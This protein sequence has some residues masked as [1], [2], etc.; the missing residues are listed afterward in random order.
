M[1]SRRSKWFIG[2]FAVGLVAF[3]ILQALS[4]RLLHELQAAVLPGGQMP[5]PEMLQRSTIFKFGPFLL[6]F[7]YIGCLFALFA[8]ISIIL[9]KRSQG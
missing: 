1:I 4:F 5:P 6:A 9:D 3:G 8:L 2:V 7:F